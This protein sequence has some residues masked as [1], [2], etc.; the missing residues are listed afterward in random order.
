MKKLVDLIEINQLIF[1]LRIIGQILIVDSW[2]GNLIINFVNCWDRIL[3]ME[4]RACY[5]ESPEKL[6]N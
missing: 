3:A 6:V 2:I 5:L 4:K 1:D